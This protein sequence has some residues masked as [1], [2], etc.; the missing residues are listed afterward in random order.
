[1]KGTKVSHRLSIVLAMMLSIACVQA[2]AQDRMQLVQDG[3]AVTEDQVRKDAAE[4]GPLLLQGSLEFY[5]RWTGLYGFHKERECALQGIMKE[6]HRIDPD[7]IKLTRENPQGGRN[8]YQAFPENSPDPTFKGY[9]L[10]VWKMICQAA[11]EDLTK[12]KSTLLVSKH[13]NDSIEPTDREVFMADFKKRKG[14]LP[15]D[16]R[17]NEFGELVIF[18]TGNN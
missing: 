10:K 14:T 2:H 1:M 7:D 17:Q 5:R 4:L 13:I 11:V 15:F 3:C 8:T 12:R 6:L 16:V 18:S 9:E